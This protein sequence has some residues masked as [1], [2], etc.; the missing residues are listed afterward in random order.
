M[1]TRQLVIAISFMSAI[2]AAYAQSDEFLG[3]SGFTGI[4]Q[5]TQTTSNV[6]GKTREQVK[7]ELKQAQDNGMKDSVAFVG[8]QP[9]VQTNAPGKTR[10]QVVAELRQSQQQG[11]VDNTGFVDAP[12]PTLKEVS[13]PIQLGL[14]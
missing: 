3:N 14:H 1:N 4:K 11:T 9:E 10:A 6:Q 12:A 13:A 7:A 5:D 2:S 8:G